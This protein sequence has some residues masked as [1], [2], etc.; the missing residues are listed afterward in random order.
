MFQL[1]TRGKPEKYDGRGGERMCHLW[2]GSALSCS[3]P[4]IMFGN[5]WDPDPGYVRCGG[6][7]LGGKDTR[8]E[9]TGKDNRIN[10]QWERAW[11]VPTTVKAVIIFFIFTG[12]KEL[13]G[14]GR[15][16]NI[17]ENRRA[18]NLLCSPS[19]SCGEDDPWNAHPP[20][21]QPWWPLHLPAVSK[22]RYRTSHGPS[23]HLPLEN[24]FFN[25]NIIDQFKRQ[26]A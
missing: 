24:K 20:H 25:I 18:A 6:E 1:G 16:P 4:C 15:S 5:D 8:T 19:S 22:E 12:P 17:S 11:L 9:T 23:K 26:H 10:W 2:L 13:N 3:C 7:Y 14:T 21:S